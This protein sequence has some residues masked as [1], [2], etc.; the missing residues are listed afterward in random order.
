MCVM[1]APEWSNAWGQKLYPELPPKQVIKD[2]DDFKTVPGTIETV[3]FLGGEPLMTNRHIRFLESFKNIGNL[4]AI[5]NTNGTFAITDR[6]KISLDKCKAVHFYISVDGYG[7]TNDRVREGSS[8]EKVTSFISQCEQYGYKFQITTT[9]HT[10]NIMQLPELHNWIVS[11]DYEWRLTFVTWP[12]H[13]ALKNLSAQDKEVIKLYCQ[14]HEVP[15]KEIL[16]KNLD[17]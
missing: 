3:L 1:C 5:Y 9:L 7:E 15:A 4:T 16:L 14:N 13:L 12:E 6:I 8:W 17:N 2:T 10:E 11:N